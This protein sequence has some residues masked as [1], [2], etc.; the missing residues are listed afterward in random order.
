MVIEVAVFADQGMWEFEGVWGLLAYAVCLA[1]EGANP[2]GVLHWLA[3][4][5]ELKDVAFLHTIK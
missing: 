4:Y 3:G 1:W 5:H 2:Q